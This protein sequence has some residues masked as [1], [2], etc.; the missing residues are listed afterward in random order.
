MQ[1][2]FGGSVR[3]RT[4]MNGLSDVDVLLVVNQSLLVNQPPSEIIAYVR[5]TIQE[6]LP[7]NSVTAGNLAVTVGYSDGTEIQM[8]P[9]IRT[10][11]GVRIAEPGSTKWSKVVQ[12]ETFAEKLAQVNQAKSGRV[13]PT[14]KLAKAMADC[15][16]TRYSRK[17][18]GYHVESLAIDAFR[19]YRGTL[20]PKAMLNHLFSHSIVAVMSP[21]KDSTG[22]SR[23]VDEYLGPTDSRPRKRA[24]TYFGQMRSKI[25]S[26][27]STA[28]F[29]DLFC[30]GN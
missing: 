16:I 14:I 4:Y 19:D 30:E 18:T 7:K 28:E 20:D 5:K 22:Q 8:L 26:C 23:Y 12:P 2:M 15:F 6:R 13:V 25:N 17:I 11:A 24:S 29:D 27:R 9:T 21:I 10:K 1:T 3:K